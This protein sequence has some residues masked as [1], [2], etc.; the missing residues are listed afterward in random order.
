MGVVTGG[1]D[2]KSKATKGMATKASYAVLALGAKTDD[3]GH[4]GN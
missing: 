3:G 2:T 1:T 4:L